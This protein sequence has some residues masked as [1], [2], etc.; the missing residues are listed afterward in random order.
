M[1][2]FDASNALRHAERLATPRLSGTEGERAAGKYIREEQEK[3][4]FGVT[5]EQFSCSELVWIFVRIS[6]GLI[7]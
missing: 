2:A 3:F 1:G 7:A 4:G 6:L 5:A